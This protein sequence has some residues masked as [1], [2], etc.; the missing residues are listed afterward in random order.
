MTAIAIAAVLGGKSLLRK[1][2]QSDAE[3]IQL[4]RQ[5]LPIA[6]LTKL[7]GDM[8]MDRTS[9]ARAV[10]ISDRTLSRRMAKKER[11]SAEES[12]RAIRLARVYATALDTLGT[13]AKA[14]SWLRHP[15]RVLDDQVPLDM[16]D[17]DAGA[18]AVETIL[19]RIAYGVYS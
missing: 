5:G 4:T 13:S 10:G 15:N 7:A 2:I 9:I 11:L 16:L 17:T 6:S 14:A 18:R 19:G 8:A 1:E 3:L 12:D